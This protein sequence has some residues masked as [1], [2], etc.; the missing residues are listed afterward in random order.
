MYLQVVQEVQPVQ[1]LPS[2]LVYPDRKQGVV[3][4]LM[5]KCILI[6]KKQQQP[7]NK[8]LKE[9]KCNLQWIPWSLSVLEHPVINTKKH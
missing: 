1:C 5:S 8:S 4:K 3:D 6:K 2:D 7:R 9:M